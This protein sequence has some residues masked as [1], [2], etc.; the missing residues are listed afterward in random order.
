[1]RFRVQLVGLAGRSSTSGTGPSSVVSNGT[2]WAAMNPGSNH[3]TVWVA[4]FSPI[5]SL[6][7]ISVIWCSLPVKR[8][9]LKSDRG[10]AFLLL[11]LPPFDDVSRRLA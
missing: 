4:L 7:D 1:M 10:S 9:V 11:G 6:N 5:S 3:L 8:S 2:H